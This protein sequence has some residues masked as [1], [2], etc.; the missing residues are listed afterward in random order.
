MKQENM[1]LGMLN[2]KIIQCDHQNTMISTVFFDTSQ[3]AETIAFCKNQRVSNYE[4]YGGYEEADRAVAVFLPDYIDTA[5]NICAYFAA[6]EEDSPV[7]LVEASAPKGSRD[8]THRDYLGSLLALGI[9]REVIGDILV[10]ENGARIFVLREMADF[11]LTNYNKAGRT[12][13]KLERIALKDFRFSEAKTEAVS[14]TVASLRLDSIVAA[15]FSMSRTKAVEY[16]KGG[17][18]F[19]NHAAVTKPDRQLQ[20]KDQVVLRGRGKIAI[21]EIGNRTR[22]DRIHVIFRKYG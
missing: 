2:D 20:E 17:T 14:S 12:N 11:L 13:L 4:F 8:L 10:F 16:I 1:L 15:A 6:Q 21:D 22:K 9:K 3:R 18:V 7:V 5:G 19:I